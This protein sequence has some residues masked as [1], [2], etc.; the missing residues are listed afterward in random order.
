MDRLAESDLCPFPEYMKNRADT[1]STAYDSGFT[2]TPGSLE[3]ICG[4]MFSGKSE[5]L[6]RRLRRA[7]IAYGSK[8]SPSSDPHANEPVLA[9]KHGS[10]DRH[11]VENVRSHDGTTFSALP[12]T[13]V[14]EILGC[15]YRPH[16]QVVGI[17]EVQFFPPE[18]VTAVCMLVHAGKKV[19]VAGLDMDFRGL[20]FGPMSTLLA[21]ADSV[22]KLSAICTQCGKDAPMTQRLVN[23]APVRFDDPVVLVGEDEY[24]A[25]CRACHKIGKSSS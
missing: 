9:F 5:E 15:Y 17:D 19:I 11:G 16:C 23:G 8:P 21:I 22:S 4:P 20:P 18:I 7:A 1:L 12:T 6:M 13:S 10:D 14:I 2:L 25:R 24:Q 3:V